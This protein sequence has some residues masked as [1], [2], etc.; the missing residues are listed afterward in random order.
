MLSRS[1]L[2]L[3]TP[4]QFSHACLSLSR[5]HVTKV[6]ATGSTPESP[7]NRIGFPYASI[8]DL[9]E[10]ALGCTDADHMIEML[11]PMLMDGRLERIQRIVSQRSFS[12]LPIVEGVYNMGEFIMDH[13]TR[14]SSK[15][16]H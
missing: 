11:S 8:L 5:P 15:R 2:K 9:T 3:N 6:R 1:I 16:F 10:G 13:R 12:V 7:T 14:L 4:C